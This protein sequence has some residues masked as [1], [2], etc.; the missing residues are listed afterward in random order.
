MTS[1]KQYLVESVMFVCTTI[2][3]LFQSGIL[4]E[5][6]VGTWQKSDIIL[7]AIND[8]RYSLHISLHGIWSRE[9]Q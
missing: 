1:I 2:L 3:P 4:Q 8:Q 6:L 5:H 9:N 7:V